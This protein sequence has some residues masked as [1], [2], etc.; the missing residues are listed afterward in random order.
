ML[1]TS[2]CLGRY[3]DRWN[4]QYYSLIMQCI[5]PIL[6]ITHA[7]HTTRRTQQ[8]LHRDLNRGDTVSII[9]MHQA[10]MKS[11]WTI[12]SAFKRRYFSR[13]LSLHRWQLLSKISRTVE[14]AWICNTH[15]FQFKCFPESWLWTQF[16]SQ[17]IS[18]SDQSIR[19]RPRRS[20]TYLLTTI[21]LL[22][23]R[24]SIS[25]SSFSSTYGCSSAAIEGFRTR[26]TRA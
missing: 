21:W 25:S 9:P 23:G 26:L 17:L 13:N 16:L 11:Y 7:T 6:F 4:K 8:L 2:H 1:S 14:S 20:G 5:Q 12:P 19:I 18:L 10:L 3:E 22:I 15:L 24:L